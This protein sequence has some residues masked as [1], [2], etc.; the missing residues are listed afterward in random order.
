MAISRTI[1]INDLTPQELAFAFSEMDSDEQA[2]FFS[3]IWHIA[4]T[5]P[6]IGW[7]Q[8]ALAIAEKSDSGARNAITMLSAHIESVAA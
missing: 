2:Q 6:G 8:Q 3:A 1:E 4:R 5:W 7:C